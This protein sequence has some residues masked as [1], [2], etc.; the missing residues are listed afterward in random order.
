MIAK[1]SLDL[2]K[3]G[4]EEGLFSG[5]GFGL[6]RKKRQSGVGTI[7]RLAFDPE[8]DRVNRDTL[9]DVASLTKP[10][11]TSMAVL[12]LAQD[13]KLGLDSPVSD[14]ISVPESL[15]GVTVKHLLTHTSGLPPIPNGEGSDTLESA[16]TSTV[17]AVPGTKYVYSDTGF[18]L[19]G[20]VVEAVGGMGLNE[21]FNQKIASPLHLTNSGFCPD[22]AKPIVATSED[23]SLDG[24]PHD[25]R[26]RALGGV[27]GHAG[28][29]ST[30]DDIILYAR[31]LL[32]AGRALLS[33][34][35]FETLF[36][37][38]L[39]PEVG[40]HS[41]AFFTTGSGY[42]PKDIGFSESSVGHS[43]FTGCFILIDRSNEAAACL[44]TNRVLNQTTE[45]AA[46][47]NWRN[48]WLKAA[49]KDLGIGAQPAD[50][51]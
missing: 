36:K 3:E 17:D 11:V 26:A 37:S 29:F 20:E 31:A 30:P 24:L 51:I 25:P 18:I 5:A 4:I 16:K 38:A 14:Y 10:L 35:Y 22:A 12:Q 39:K 44:L 46:F 42:M 7:G 1:C 32:G 23:E 27:A 15:R 49:A 28:L 8:C 43:G 40:F 41:T 45:Q 9:F 47:L 13:G 6:I 21:W 48:R 50:I 34:E 19:L 33:E 2:L